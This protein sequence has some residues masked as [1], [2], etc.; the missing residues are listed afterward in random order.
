MTTTLQGP[1]TLGGLT[2]LCAQY[3][4]AKAELE[5]AGE[6]LVPTHARYDAR[7]GIAKVQCAAS[8]MTTASA[9]PRC[10]ARR[11]IDQGLLQPP[12]MDEETVISHLRGHLAGLHDLISEPETALEVGA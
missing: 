8:K 4:E 1:V 10:A 2:R 9:A 7:N 5:R 6:E 3:L 12:A 11:A